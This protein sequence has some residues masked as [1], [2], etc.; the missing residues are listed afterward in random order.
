MIT[1]GIEFAGLEPYKIAW[2]SNTIRW[3]GYRISG[4]E[5]YKIAWFS[6]KLDK[7]DVYVK[8]LEPYK[9]AWFSKISVNFNLKFLGLTK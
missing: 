7:N 2:F 8:G 3:V 4:L 6:N 1:S 5:P 9:I